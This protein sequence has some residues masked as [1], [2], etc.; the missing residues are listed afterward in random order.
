MNAG[1]SVDDM[2][3]VPV[4]TLYGWRLRGDGS[5]IWLS[6]RA[7]CPLSRS[8]VEAWLELQTD[9]RRDCRASESCR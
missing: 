7:A 4:N 1:R 9:G 6:S 8:A 3:G 2:L 5:P